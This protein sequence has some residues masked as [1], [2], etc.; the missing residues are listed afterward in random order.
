M[1]AKCPSCHGI[2]S[3]DHTGVQ[4][5]P[6][7]GKQ[8]NVAAAEGQGGPVGPGV[9]PPPSGQG[10][11]QRGPTPWEDRASLGAGRGLLE[12]WKQSMLNPDAFFRRVRPDGPVSDALFFGWISSAIG[13]GLSLPFQ[14]LGARGRAVELPPDF[15]QYRPVLEAF[16]S[17]SGMGGS[18]IAGLLFYPVAIFIGAAFIH[19]F[20][21][22][23]GASKNGYWATF[24]VLAYA[25]GPAIFSW[26][27]CVGALAGLYSLVLAV[28]GIM[29]VQE[30]SGGRATAAALGPMI[31]L[32]CCCGLAVA[33]IAASLA[34]LPGIGLGG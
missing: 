29:H 21:L 32:C 14:L 1:E 11:G 8:V 34:G 6:N 9:L 23:L 16:T 15:E 22:L 3:T 20:C 2:F 5:C 13:L 18:I 26:V 17:T 4:F 12:T 27:P 7:C 33:G 10:E 30:T 24:R 31:L 25:G 19:L 28:F